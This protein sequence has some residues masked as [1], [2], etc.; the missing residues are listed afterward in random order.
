MGL[1]S[2]ARVVNKYRVSGSCINK[3]IDLL[4]FHIQSHPGLSLFDGDGSQTGLWG[5]SGGVLRITSPGRE[6]C[7][8]PL[9]A[10]EARTITLPM[11]LLPT[12][13]TRPRRK[14]P[15]WALFAPVSKLT[16]KVTRGLT[17]AS[18]IGSLRLGPLVS[19]FLW[20][21]QLLKCEPVPYPVILPFSPYPV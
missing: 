21:W 6:V 11:S 4:T 10:L 13:R 7:S 16:S 2:G 9:P 14:I 20:Q 12:E 1:T 5:P 3:K 8:W 19:L 15:S 18:A 17:W